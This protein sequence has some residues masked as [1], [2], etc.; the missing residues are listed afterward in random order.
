MITT[1]LD[2]G[3]VGPCTAPLIADAD[4]CFDVVT[5]TPDTVVVAVGLGLA[6][7]LADTDVCFDVVTT[8]PDVD[9]AVAV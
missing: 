8:T 7:S 9:T 3:T 4:V 5:T 6:P 2:P 1:T